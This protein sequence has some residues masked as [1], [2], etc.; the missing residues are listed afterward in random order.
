MEIKLNEQEILKEAD[1]LI[2]KRVVNERIKELEELYGVS[3]DIIDT[4]KANIKKAEEQKEAL[5]KVIVMQMKKSEVTAEN[6]KIMGKEY[7]DT[8]FL[9]RAE[10]KALRGRIKD[11]QN[12]KGK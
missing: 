11:I 7:K 8:V 6:I 2:E 4:L 5:K 9:L 12:K 3:K 10:N 1:R